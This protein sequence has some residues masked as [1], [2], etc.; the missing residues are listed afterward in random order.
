[1]ENVQSHTK[2]SQ[3]KFVP[4]FLSCAHL[5]PICD[6]ILHYGTES[7]LPNHEYISPRYRNFKF[8]LIFTIFRSTPSTRSIYLPDS[9][10]CL[11]RVIQLCMEKTQLDPEHESCHSMKNL[12]LFLGRVYPFQI[13]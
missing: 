11:I 2:L 10:S 8:K 9:I 3:W 6:E 1:M 7:A 13:L 5:L 12:R 4:A